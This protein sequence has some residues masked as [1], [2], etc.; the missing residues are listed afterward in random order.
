[1]NKQVETTVTQNIF[2]ILLAL[3]MIL[4]GLVILLLIE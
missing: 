2:R 3:F 1:M 4:R